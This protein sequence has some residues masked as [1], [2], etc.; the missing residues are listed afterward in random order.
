MLATPLILITLVQQERILSP[1]GIV[2]IKELF[3]YKLQTE[4]KPLKV[5]SLMVEESEENSYQATLGEE[6]I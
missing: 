3:K 4:D 2:P 6:G 5:M 1:E